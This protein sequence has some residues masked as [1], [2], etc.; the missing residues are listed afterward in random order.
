MSVI[1][2]LLLEAAAAWRADRRIEHAL[3]QLVGDVARVHPPHRPSGVERLEEV[4]RVTSHAPSSTACRR[5]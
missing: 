1:T 4:Q 5:D 3:D 2:I